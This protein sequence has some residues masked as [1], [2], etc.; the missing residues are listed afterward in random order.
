MIRNVGSFS[1]HLI[2]V[3]PGLALGAVTWRWVKAALEVTRSFD[4]RDALDHIDTPVL[5]ASAAEE[6]LVDNDAHSRI[7]AKLSNATHIVLSMV[8]AM[9]FSW[10]PKTSGLNSMPLSMPS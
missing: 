3:N 8:H 9:K 5:V 6:Q 4:A 7:A 2:R 1:A 10:K